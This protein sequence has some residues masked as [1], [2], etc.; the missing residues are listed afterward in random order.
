MSGAL[1]EYLRING[2][3][4]LCSH[5][6]S[7][8]PQCL[9]SEKGEPTLE[10]QARVI[11]ATAQKPK[12]KDPKL[13]EAARKETVSLKD[14]PWDCEQ[15]GHV[16]FHLSTPQFVV[17]DPMTWEEDSEGPYEVKNFSGSGL[18]RLPVAAIKEAREDKRGV[19]VDS[20]T[21]MFVDNALYPDFVESFEWDKANT[22]SGDPDWNYHQQIAEQ[23][24]TRFGVCST[25]PAKYKSQFTG[26]GFYT[27]DA[28]RIRKV[29]AN[30]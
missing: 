27:V 6:K 8:N 16:Y 26:D 28:K 7:L 29:A 14:V 5:S 2:V 15:D 18:Y 21:L 23:I 11:G 17:L 1:M 30:G 3:K 13:I 9:F 4:G 19:A 24:G 20:A 22:K 12:Q 25:P 10:P